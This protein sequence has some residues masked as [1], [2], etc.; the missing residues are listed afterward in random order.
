MLIRSLSSIPGMLKYRTRIRRALSDSYS[1]FA[2]G[3]L[4]VASGTVLVQASSA[5]DYVELLG[6]QLA[7]GGTIG[8]AVSAPLI[9]SSL[10]ATWLRPA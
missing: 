10:T 9:V 5:T 6:Y 7:S 3:F 8:T 1:S 2:G 4:A